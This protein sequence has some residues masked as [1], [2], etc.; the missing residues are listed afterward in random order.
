MIRQV[1]RQVEMVGYDGHTGTH[2]PK[3]PKI[4]EQDDEKVVESSM[5]K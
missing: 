5:L 2:L 3:R 1:R 4:H